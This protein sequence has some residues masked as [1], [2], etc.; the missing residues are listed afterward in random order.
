MP[1]DDA[2]RAPKEEALAEVRDAL[3][4]LQSVPGVALDQQKLEHLECA[5]TD[6]EAL[7]RALTNEVEQQRGDER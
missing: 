2:R 4:A 6:V 5:C 7:E 3:A 1:T